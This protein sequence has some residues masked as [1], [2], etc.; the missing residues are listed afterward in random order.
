MVGPLA[1]VAAVTVSLTRPVH[2]AL[3]PLVSDT[4]GELTAANAATGSVEAAATLVGPL[5]SGAVIALWAPGGVL[6]V[7][8]VC[9]VGS[10][11]VVLGLG[12]HAGEHAGRRTRTGCSPA[13]GPAGPG[14][15]AVGRA[16]GRARTC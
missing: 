13:D 16:R 8:S 2:N 6:L 3:L 12:T 1:A 7:M 4:T 10:T 5:V 11:V 14:G 9:A 15:P